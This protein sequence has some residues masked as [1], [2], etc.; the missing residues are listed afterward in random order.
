MGPG[1]YN[2]SFKQIHQRVKGY[3]MSKGLGRKPPPKKSRVP[4]KVLV[5][6]GDYDPVESIPN[7]F[8]HMQK[9]ETEEGTLQKKI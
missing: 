6:P 1:K 8:G 4:K 9:K 2:P 5:G 3:D 7:T